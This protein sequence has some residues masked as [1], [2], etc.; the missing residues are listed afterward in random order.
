[1]L[2]YTYKNATENAVDILVGFLTCI[3]TVLVIYALTKKFTPKFSEKLSDKKLSK[4][5]KERKVHNISVLCRIE[6]LLDSHPYDLSGG[7]QQR[8]ALAKI[9]LLNPEILLLD[10]PTKG[11][12]ASFKENFAVILK[13]LK[14]SGKTVVMVSHDIHRAIKY[15]GKVIELKNGE[16]TFIGKAND[17][18]CGGAV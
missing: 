6:N 12:D 15:C 16:V 13:N 8:V 1:M 11:M 18:K 14:Q 4:E 10:E 7:E 5:E 17:Y 2:N 3:V 9:L